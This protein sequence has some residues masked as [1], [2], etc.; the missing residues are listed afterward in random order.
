MWEPMGAEE[1]LKEWG[2]EKFYPGWAEPTPSAALGRMMDVGKDKRRAQARRI[3]Q[4]LD[5]YVFFRKTNREPI[6]CHETRGIRMENIVIDGETTV[7]PPDGGMGAMVERMASAIERSH[8]CRAVGELLDRMPRDMFT[9]AYETYGNCASPR[10]VPNTAQGAARRIGISER[11]YFTRKKQ[12]L[13]W[14]SEQLGITAEQR[15]A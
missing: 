1:R 11:T 14:L 5:R 3:R 9:I 2:R 10:D 8:R 12:M 15:A 6:A 7:C 13:R 4:L